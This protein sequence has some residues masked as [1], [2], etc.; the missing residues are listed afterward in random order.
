M[1]KIFYIYLIICLIII[2]SGILLLLFMFGHNLFK[3][4]GVIIVIIGYILS[5]GLRDEIFY[6]NN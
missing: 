6:K 2:F 1:K 3:D 5:I 4:W